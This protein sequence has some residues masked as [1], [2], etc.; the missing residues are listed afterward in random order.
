VDGYQ[1]FT[2]PRYDAG[3]GRYSHTRGAHV[4]D[5]AVHLF[6]HA[7]DVHPPA[8][9]RAGRILFSENAFFFSVQDARLSLA[10]LRVIAIAM[11]SISLSLPESAA[12]HLSHLREEFGHKGSGLSAKALQKVYGLIH[13]A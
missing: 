10:G 12:G 13:L 5:I 2:A 9:L 11:K 4:A 3:A 8:T 1:L 6:R 7:G